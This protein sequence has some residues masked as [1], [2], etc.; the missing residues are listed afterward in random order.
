MLDIIYYY[1]IA[2]INI[3]TDIIM[4]IDIGIIS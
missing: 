4:I 2:I 3:I 1:F